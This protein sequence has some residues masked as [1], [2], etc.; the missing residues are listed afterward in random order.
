MFIRLLIEAGTPPREAFDIV[1]DRTV[2]S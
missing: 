2:R 1:M